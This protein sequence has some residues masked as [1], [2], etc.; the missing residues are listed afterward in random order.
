MPLIQDWSNRHVIYTAGHTDEQADRMAK[1]PRAYVSFLA[2]GIVRRHHEPTKPHP[3]SL[4]GKLKRDWAVSLG[5]AGS[6]SYPAKYTF[7][8]NA[9]PSCANDF[10]VFSTS[11]TGSSRANVYGTFTNDPAIGQTVSITITPTSSSPI[12]L[13][14]TA[15][16]SNS[17]TTFAVSGTNNTATDAGNFAAAINRNLSSIALDELA[18]VE[19]PSSGSSSSVTVYA[20]TPGTGVTLSTASH[21]SNFSWGLPTAGRNGTGANI[22]GL[23]NLYAGSGSP[24]CSGYT[25]PTFTFSYSA[26]TGSIPTSPVLSLDGRK[27]AFVE[28]AISG[29]ILHVLTVGTGTEHGSCTNSGT[30][31]PTCATAAVI[32]GSTPGSNATDY[33]LPMWPGGLGATND[34][35]SSPF[36]DYA[37]DV[38]YVGDDSGNLYSVSPVF[39]GGTPTIRSSFPVVVDTLNIGLSSPVVDVGNS[40]DVFVAD[41]AGAR[42]YKVTSDGVVEGYSTIGT[43]EGRVADNGPVV[44]STNGVG[45]VASPCNAANSSSPVVVQFSTTGTGSPELLAT[46][47]LSASACSAIFGPTPDNNY[48]TKGISSST[49]GN[50]GE[51][52]VAYDSRP[53]SLTQIQFTSG[54]MNTTAEY[55]DTDNGGFGN[56]NFSFSPLTEFYGNDQAYAISAVTQSGN[57]LTVTTTANAFVSNQVVVISGVV[58]GT[59]GCT[60]A[61]VRAM[62]GEPTVTVT[63]PTTFSFTSAVDANIGGANGNCNLASALAIGPTQ[64]YLFFGSAFPAEVST[65]DLPLTSDTQTAAA[66]NATS[67][68]SNGTSGIIIDNDSSEGQA[69][70]IYFTTQGTTS[71]CGISSYCAVK[72][73][74]A[75]LN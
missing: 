23:N 14:L 70:S 58:A 5:N 11:G 4:H 72:L 21:L 75:G 1:D 19:N 66:T 29:P 41:A 50:N 36:V 27:I 47:D 24:L 26:G 52:L 46:A 45:Y 42:L 3:V 63:S 34:T 37:N 33:M 64:D 18:A 13:T 71:S 31:A 16:T 28:N 65:F 15:G 20:L 49:P 67:V 25:Y 69:S 12:T 48:F 55:T 39:G 68:G 8:V 35:L 51:L 6:Y 59:G 7:D 2:H 32:P 44:D 17:G 40:G 22:V 53:G 62:G 54:I 9:P 10:V 43:R 57:R 60:S 30:V 56:L 61:A 38:L 74:Q 73:T